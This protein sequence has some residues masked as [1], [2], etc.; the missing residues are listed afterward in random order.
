ME[1]LTRDVSD[2]IGMDGEPNGVPFQEY[3]LKTTTINGKTYLVG[4]YKYE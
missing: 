2:C 1:L 4:T 3:V